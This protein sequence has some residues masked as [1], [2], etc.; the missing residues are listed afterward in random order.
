MIK[1]LEVALGLIAPSQVNPA[2]VLVLTQILGSYT[3]MMLPT[4]SGITTQQGIFIH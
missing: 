4:S 1:T 2:G 3:T